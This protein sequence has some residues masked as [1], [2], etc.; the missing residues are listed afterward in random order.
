[1]SE[2]E[3]SHIEV[4]LVR[5]PDWLKSHE[6]RGFFLSENLPIIDLAIP[7]QFQ[8]MC[9]ADYGELVNWFVRQIHAP[10]MIREE[11]D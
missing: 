5:N 11:L 4:R 1:M 7:T 8:N 6:K 3:F 2:P 10:L 9:E